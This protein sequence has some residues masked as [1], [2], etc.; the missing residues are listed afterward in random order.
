MVL[1]DA[2]QLANRLFPDG[3]ADLTVSLIESM[4]EAFGDEGLERLP[5]IR[6]RKQVMNYRGKMSFGCFSFGSLIYTKG[7]S[8]FCVWILLS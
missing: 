4:K 5:E 8:P 3:Y 2:L 7:W 1:W 6:T